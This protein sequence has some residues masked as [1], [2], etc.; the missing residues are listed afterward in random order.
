MAWDEKVKFSSFLRQG[1]RKS[2]ECHTRLLLWNKT[3]YRVKYHFEKLC[4]ALFILTVYLNIISN[5]F[6]PH[7]FYKEK[8]S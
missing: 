8:P 7:T 1:M 2:S 6:V 4:V 3:N 5:D